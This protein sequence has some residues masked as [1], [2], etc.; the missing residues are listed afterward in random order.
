[1]NA[2]TQSLRI[3]I[4]S[5]ADVQPER[6]RA[7]LFIE[8][9][10]KDYGRFF[11]V[12]PVL[13]ESE[14]MMASGHFQD[15]IVP[16]SE[17]DIVILILWS[18]LGTALPARTEKREY[19]GLD[20]HVPVTGTEWEFEDALQA[21]KRKGVP[22]LLAYRKKGPARAEYGSAAEAQELG[23]QL[24]TLERFWGRYFA[25]GC[26]FRAAFSEFTDLDGF[27]ARLESDLRRLIER[28]AAMLDDRAVASPPA[29]WLK[30][31]PFRG[32]QAYQF[33]H[34]AIFFG[35]AEGTKVA[36]ERLVANSESGRPFLLVLG[37]SG[38][39][40]SSLA[41]AGIVPALCARGV[42]AGIG[43]WFRAIMRPGGHPPGPFAALAA[44][45]TAEYALPELL[46]GQTVADLARHLEVAAADPTFLIVSALSARE[47]AARARGDLLSHEQ[48]RLVLVVDQLEE[49][50]T[51]GT[52]TQDMRAR[53]VLC[54]QGLVRSG[55]VFVVATMRSD[56]WH[57]AAELPVLAALSDGSGRFDLLPA[58]QPEIADMMRRAAEAA[59]LTFEVDPRSEIRLDAFLASEAAGEP[60]SLPLLSFLLDSLYATDVRDG[61]STLTYG[62]MRALGA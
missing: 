56:Y 37:A 55:R 24:Q 40:K 51:L 50:F 42:V 44:A 20:G 57:R 35:R 41:Q 15:A 26:E 34:A 11:A 5:P 2:V 12:T 23:R 39:G 32:L 36:V 52:L 18:R 46:A 4:S 6:R 21:N 30:G 54:L 9:L 43:A 1:V 53:F 28:R 61:R 49:L 3:F 14:P 38:S 62:T 59:G 45:L 16:P 31:T 29:M 22:D 48:T 27:E 33:E 8:K 10:A 25:G 13:W 7:A 17:T 47:T 60:G 19:R 58:T